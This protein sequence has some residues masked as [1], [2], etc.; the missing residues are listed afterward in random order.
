[1]NPDTSSSRLWSRWR[2][3]AT[4]VDKSGEYS[5]LVEIDGVK[6]WIH[7]NKLRKFDVR[8]ADVICESFTGNELFAIVDPCSVI[9]DK[10][11]E[12]GYVDA[13]DLHII[14]DLSL[15][16]RKVDLS[17]F[18]HLN[19][20]Q[21]QEFLAVLDKYPEVFS[22]V[23]GYCDQIPHEI[24]VS[25]NF[26]PKRLIPYKIPEKLKPQ[27]DDAIQELLRLGLI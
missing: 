9:H 18:A 26:V 1:L 12:F 23:P 4:I 17:K 16:S 24:K 27:V 20:Q 7:A 5:Y 25:D 3:P 13:I 2:A 11:C 21:R 6:Q 10:D 8:V 14:E 22:E 15:P 19:E